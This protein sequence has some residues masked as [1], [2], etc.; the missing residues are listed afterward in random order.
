MNI[1]QM[2]IHSNKHTSLKKHCCGMNVHGR[3]TCRKYEH[4][5]LFA[6]WYTAENI[7]K[8]NERKAAV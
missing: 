6:E 5:T 8:K 4:C 3:T 1:R 2:E 7:V